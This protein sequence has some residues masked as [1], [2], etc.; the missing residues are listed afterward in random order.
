[1]S[2][3]MHSLLLLLFPCFRGV[4]AADPGVTEDQS[5]QISAVLDTLK[6]ILASVAN[7]ETQETQ[8]YES[9]NLSC[10]KDA[11][12]TSEQLEETKNNFEFCQMTGE[13][14]SA[15]VE[16]LTQTIQ[17]TSAE[18]QSTRNTIAQAENIRNAD[19]DKYTE[20][21]QLNAQ[22]IAQVQKAIKI[23]GV[24]HGRGFLQNGGRR[25]KQQ[26][27]LRVSEPGESDYVLGIM[28]GLEDR[29]TKNRQDMEAAENDAKRVYDALMQTQRAREAELD[30]TI[31]E[32]KRELQSLRVYLVEQKQDFERLSKKLKTTETVLLEIQRSCKAKAVW[33]ETRCEDRAQ[34]KVALQQAIDEFPKL[35]DNAPI[36]EGKLVDNV[37]TRKGK[38]K[39]V[40]SFFQVVS[41][42]AR[43]TANAR[44]EPTRTKKLALLGV[45]DAQSSGLASGV[46][47]SSS[48]GSMDAAK[49]EVKNLLSVLLA[50]HE[51][52]KSKKKHCEENLAKTSAEQGSLEKDAGLVNASI[53]T[54]TNEANLMNQEI[55]AIDEALDTMKKDVEDATTI[56]KKEK[57]TYDS[58]RK[59]TDLA[60]KVLQQAARILRSFYET[61]DTLGKRKTVRSN[62]AVAMIETVI[63]DILRDQKSAEEEEARSVRAFE[64]LQIDKREE[65]DEQ[66]EE[67][68]VRK[69]RKA[70][71]LVEQGSEEEDKEQLDEDIASVKDQMNN[72]NKE[73]QDLLTHYD[74][75]RTARS[76]E[77]SQ[78]RDAFDILS[79][80][81]VAVRT[82]A[83]IDADAQ[84]D[85]LLQ[86]MTRAVSNLTSGSA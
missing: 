55:K 33:W 74:Q 51:A 66:I 5:K 19:N 4:L 3:L 82:G 31:T 69:Q 32:K 85:A 7:E 67:L 35:V 71:L 63:E 39:G 65:F 76:F 1:M 41:A 20:D 83:F 70:T 81:Q 10:V 40:A 9:F 84:E 14:M 21:M 15:S 72:L 57:Q 18:L 75:R 29:L 16:S 80:S 28:Q 53:E 43:S 8:N 11:K 73:C 30:G 86:D 49:K 27:H 60:V 52:E 24:V 47:G 54:K 34:E 48:K 6:D 42:R 58:G 13:E 23:V 77:I 38:G 12:S 79:G 17:D 56:R 62:I 26:S 2:A 25:E 59:D 46:S 61:K 36:G 64:K 45:A 68:T 44:S 50:Q 22:S 78:L 37:S